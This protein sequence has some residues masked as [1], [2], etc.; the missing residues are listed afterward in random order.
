MLKLVLAFNFTETR[1]KALRLAALLCRAQVKVVPR[2]D[3]LQSLGYL[4]GLPD[5]EAGQDVYRGEEATAEMIYMCGFTR[6]DLDRMLQ[7]IKR[8]RLGSIKLKSMLTPINIS[9][10]PL[11][12]MTELSQ[13]HEYMTKKGR[14][15]PEHSQ[16]D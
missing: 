14:A 1:L 13:E 7:G 2:K 16:Q 15:K 11:K 10:T 5:M 9:W 4:A 6:A 3:F 12:L 8:S